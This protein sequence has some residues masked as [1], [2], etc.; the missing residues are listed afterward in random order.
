MDLRLGK[1]GAR[2]GEDEI[3]AAGQLQSPAQAITANRDEYRNG[4]FKQGQHGP[5][6]QTQHSFAVFRQMFLNARSET[7]IRALG[8]K[9][10]RRKFRPLTIDR[11]GLRKGREHGRI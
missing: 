2:R 3:T 8:A 9:Q 1:Y 4:I 6:D 7:E 5:V 10:Y 11:K